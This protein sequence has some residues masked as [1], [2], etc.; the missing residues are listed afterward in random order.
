M[1]GH[2]KWANIKHKK[3][4]TDAKRGKVFS[5]IVKEITVAARM[6]GGEPE[7]NPRLRTALIAAKAANMP[8]DNINNAI[9]KGI[10]AVAGASM[11]EEITYEGYAPDGVAIVIDSLTDN[12]NRALSD[13]RTIVQKNGGK[14][15]EKGAV[16]WNFTTKGLIVV[17]AEGVDEDEI[18]EFALEAGAEDVTPHGEVIEITTELGDYLTVAE[19]FDASDYKIEVSEIAKIAG[20]TTAISGTSIDKIERLISAVEDNEDVQ[21]VYSN[22]EYEH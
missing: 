7:M 17:D 6:G 4:A 22:A 2:S 14:M 3:G 10:G 15:A 20:T 18:M 9:K 13:I 19:A 21:K 5:K 12:K 1:A 11:Y 8:K 16:S